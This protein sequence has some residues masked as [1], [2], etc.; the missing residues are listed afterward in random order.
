MAR[1]LSFNIERFFFDEIS[2]TGNKKK[3]SG[4]LGRNLKKE[5]PEHSPYFLEKKREKREKFVRFRQ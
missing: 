3:P 2:P 4:P 5:L 1:I